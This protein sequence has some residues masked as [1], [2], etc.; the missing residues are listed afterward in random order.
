MPVT[1]FFDP[2]QAVRYALRR[3]HVPTC[4]LAD[5]TSVPT[6]WDDFGF[7]DL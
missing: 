4:L 1:G 3:V 6:E 2:P 5:G 7:C